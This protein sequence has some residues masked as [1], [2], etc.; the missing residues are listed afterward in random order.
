[1]IISG[2][3]SYLCTLR[4]YSGGIGP[5]YP[6]IGCPA[7]RKWRLNDAVR[8]CKSRLRVIADMTRYI[9][10]PTKRQEAPGRSP[11]PTMLTSN[12]DPAPA[13]LARVPLFEIF[14]GFVVVNCDC[15]TRIYFNCCRPSMFTFVKRALKETSDPKNS[16]A[17]GPRSPVF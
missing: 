8:P 6:Y 16:T 13:R 3:G 2:S 5:Q 1:M 10:L 4:T 15:I 12:A 17:P 14:S 11:S 7:C 9:L